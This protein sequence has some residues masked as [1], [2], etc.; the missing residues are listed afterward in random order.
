MEA[1]IVSN[2]H[3]IM[4]S[5]PHHC[6]RDLAKIHGPIM[7]IKLGEV[8]TVFVSKP[9]A[10]KEIMKTHDSVFAYRPHLLTPNIIS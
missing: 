3:Q 6:L 2:M 4:G 8:S 10:A 1:T 9:E 5:S 7:H